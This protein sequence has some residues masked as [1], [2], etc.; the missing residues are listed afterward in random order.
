[1][2]IQKDPFNPRQQT[3]SQG[4]VSG[5]ESHGTPHERAA[6]PPQNTGTD[7]GGSGPQEK[8][9]PK[10]LNLI[11]PPAGHRYMRGRY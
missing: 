9:Q 4:E 2:P 1:M 7:P 3:S 10:R 6:L 8:P 5:Q 11:T